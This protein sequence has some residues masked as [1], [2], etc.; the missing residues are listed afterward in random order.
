[1][2]TAAYHEAWVPPRLRLEGAELCVLLPVDSAPS[3]LAQAARF[4]AKRAAPPKPKAKPGQSL[5]E[6][7]DAS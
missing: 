1:M 7:I 5:L 3:E 6:R 4:I 2:N